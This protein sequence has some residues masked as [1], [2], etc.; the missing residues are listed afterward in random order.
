MIR[1]YKMLST[2][3]LS[4]ADGGTHE[5]DAILYP[6]AGDVVQPPRPPKKILQKDLT[7]S[8]KGA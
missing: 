1:G 8:R 5:I 7:E 3:C 2:Q 4:L 6:A